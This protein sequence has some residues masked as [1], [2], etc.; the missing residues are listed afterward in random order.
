VG[1]ASIIEKRGSRLLFLVR[2]RWGKK[3]EKRIAEN[4][5]KVPKTKKCFFA[6]CN[7]NR[8]NRYEGGRG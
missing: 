5:R 2:E 7:H 4:G 6:C 8:V 3:K 1:E